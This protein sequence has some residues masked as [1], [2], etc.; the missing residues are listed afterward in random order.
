[1]KFRVKFSKLETDFK[2]KFGEVNN[3]SDGGFE[4]GYTKGY[5]VGNTEGYNKGHTDGV[6]QGYTK[7]YTE[8]AEK[9][10]DDGLAARTYETW[11]ITYTDG[12][13]EEVEV[14]LI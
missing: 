13:T 6:E 3:L 8:G 14:A 11:E 7:G 5:E 9:G 12:T 2:A 1:M 10:Y 4:R